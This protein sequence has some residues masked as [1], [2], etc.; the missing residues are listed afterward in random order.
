MTPEEALIDQIQTAAICA[1]IMNQEGCNEQ[2]AFK[3]LARMC[4]LTQMA[5]GIDAKALPSKFSRSEKAAE[6]SNLHTDD[7]LMHWVFGII[8]GE[9]N[10]SGAFLDH[11]AQAAVRADLESYAALRP[12]LLE[13]KKR[14][15]KYECKCHA[16]SSRDE[17]NL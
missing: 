17:E 8:H 11:L 10:K 6:Y 13:L 14:F 5:L 2:A 3:I 12:A 1:Y 4:A 15:P 7:E 9:P 16:F